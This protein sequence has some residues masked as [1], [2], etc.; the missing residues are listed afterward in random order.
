VTRRSIFA[1]ALVSA[2]VSLAGCSGAS[3]DGDVRSIEP[4]TPDGPAGKLTTISLRKVANGFGALTHL[5]APAGDNRLWVVEQVGRVLIVDGAKHTVALDIS[6]RVGSDG[7]EQGLLSIAFH[8]MYDDRRLVYANYTDRNGNTHVSSFEVHSDTIDADSERV[9]L[10]VDQ[11]YANHN[12]G[13]IAF[14]PDGM[15][16]I[17]MGDGGSGGDPHG[18]GQDASTL[19]G[20]L[21]RIDVN[22]RT[23]GLMYGI[24][25]D[26]PFADGDDGAPEVWAIGLRNPWRFS[27]DR[28]SKAL[29]IGDVG[30]EQ[31]EEIDIVQAPQLVRPPHDPLNF[32]WNTYEATHKY[33][34]GGALSTGTLVEPILEYSHAHGCSITGGHVYRGK[35]SPALRGWYVYADYCSNWISALHRGKDIRPKVV[36]SPGVGQVASFGEAT[37][38]ELYAVT[39]DG[40]IYAIGG[41]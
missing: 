28:E 13:Q 23:R 11:P 5:T 22:S 18:H 29:F 9:L 38:G 20:A 27:F 4:S 16:Y 36:E 25:P 39:L 35:R 10:Q 34:G 1:L 41:R 19:L 32:G 40:A 6:D 33:D 17:G 12:G 31:W 7:S 26:N 15:L 24:P 37:D 3:T 14:G 2:A 21:L 8:P 30:Q